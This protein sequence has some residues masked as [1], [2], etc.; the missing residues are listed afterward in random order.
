MIADPDDLT[1][2]DDFTL[3]EAAAWG[4]L[5]LVGVAASATY[6]AATAWMF[7]AGWAILRDEQARRFLGLP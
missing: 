2:D 5:A 7:R 4:G 1:T 6:L 3:S